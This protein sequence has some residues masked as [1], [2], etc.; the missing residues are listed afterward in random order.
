[1][2]DDDLAGPD[3]VTDDETETTETHAGLSLPAVDRPSGKGMAAEPTHRFEDGE[4]GLG[5][6]P[7]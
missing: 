5:G 7:R 6:G 2:N 4:G 1:M 3:L